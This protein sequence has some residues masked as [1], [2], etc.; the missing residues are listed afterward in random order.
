MGNKKA[1]GTEIYNFCPTLSVGFNLTDYSFYTGPILSTLALA[2]GHG[3]SWHWV[4]LRD[5]SILDGK[6]YYEY[7]YIILKNKF[8][9]WPL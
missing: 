1:P 8:E 4:E 5:P 9:S 7:L 3:V 6:N 2:A